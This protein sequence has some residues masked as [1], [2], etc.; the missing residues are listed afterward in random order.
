M[1]KLILLLFVLTSTLLLNAQSAEKEQ[2]SAN[3]NSLSDEEFFT[4]ADLV[5]EWQFLRIVETYDTKGNKKYD[6][7]PE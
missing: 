4:K 1:K 6:D 3:E 2:N 7:I 5:V